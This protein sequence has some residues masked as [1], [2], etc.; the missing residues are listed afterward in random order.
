MLDAGRQV[1][2]FGSIKDVAIAEQIHT[3]TKGRCVQLAGRTELGE[4]IDLMS[5]ASTV[6]TNDSG[7]MHV[8]AAVGCHVIALYGSSSDEFTP[9]LTQTAERLSVEIDC[10]PCFQRKCPLHHLNCLKTLAPE[11]VIQHLSRT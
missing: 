11:T 9:P 6:V 7:L 1:W 10:R 5:V 8:A 3:A 2:L 4:A